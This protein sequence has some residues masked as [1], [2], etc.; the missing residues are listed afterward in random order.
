MKLS[1]LLDE[2]YFDEDTFNLHLANNLEPI[3]SSSLNKDELAHCDLYWIANGLV[4][5]VGKNYK[6]DIDYD[7][8]L[9]RALENLDQ[10]EAYVFDVLY[11]EDNDDSYDPNVKKYSSLS[12]QEKIQDNIDSFSEDEGKYFL[13]YRKDRD[14]IKLI[15]SY[16]SNQ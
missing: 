12:I 2:P 4:N 15:K 9:K 5:I 7:L 6:Y 13:D 3:E 16:C 14:I 10:L 1:R 11:Y 8:F